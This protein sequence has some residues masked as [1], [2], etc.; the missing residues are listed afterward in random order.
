[1]R[2]SA[3]V[4]VA[5]GAALALAGCAGLPAGVDGDLTNNWPAMAQPKVAVP[6]A[7]RCYADPPKEVWIGDFVT[8]PCTGRHQ[9]ET[10]FVGTFTGA[11]ADRSGPPEAGSQGRVDAF[12]QCRQATKDYLG[13][14]F[15]MGRLDL[16][17]V[18][19]SAP[20]WV[21]GARWFRCDV[22]QY[23][24]L[25]NSDIYVD[26]RSVK[27]GLRGARPLALTCIVATDDGKNSITDE[28]PVDCASPH[29][30]ELAGLFTA[31]DVPW[32]ADKTARDDIASKGCEAVAAGYLGLPGG[33]VTNPVFGWG[34]DTF[35]EEQWKL[36]DRTVRCM[37]LGFKGKSVNG[38]RFTG[39][40]K[41]IGNR[42]PT[43]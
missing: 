25:Y 34:Y 32:Q 27:D 36:G 7:G 35:T 24:D 1:M 23:T 29:N 21:G 38:E 41:G 10:S 30:G 6:E 28:Q 15:L 9:S 12:A 26:G 22:V 33:K 19:P 3:F 14:D 37:V 40:V 31:P 20:A 13:D 42:A 43:G 39:S 18:L 5:V 17:L 8:V 4:V 11:N 16:A 2:R